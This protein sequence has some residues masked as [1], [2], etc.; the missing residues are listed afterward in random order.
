MNA[1]PS[2][3]MM[4]VKAHKKI[5]YEIRCKVAGANLD[6]GAYLDPDHTGEELDAIVEWLD[7]MGEA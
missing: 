7:K 6:L 5:L 4:T 1:Q 3:P 2:E